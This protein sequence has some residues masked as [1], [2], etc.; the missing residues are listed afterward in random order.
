MHRPMLPRSC[1][2]FRCPAL[3][4]R[5]I[6]ALHPTIHPKPLLAPRQLVRWPRS[7][8]ASHYPAIR[9]PLLNAHRWQSEV[10]C[11]VSS[12][13]LTRIA[14]YRSPSSP[15]I[16]RSPLVLV[17]PVACQH[18]PLLPGVS[19]RRSPTHTLSSYCQRPHWPLPLAI[20]ST[21]LAPPLLIPLYLSSPNALNQYCTCLGPAICELTLKILEMVQYNRSRILWARCL[22]LVNVL[23]KDPDVSGP[24]TSPAPAHTPGPDTAM[25]ARE[26]LVLWSAS[27]NSNVSTRTLHVSIRKSVIY[28]VLLT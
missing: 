14:R 13:Q 11:T 5:V 23:A 28:L 2:L 8:A 12:L 1:G 16:R 3:S 26:V 15:A 19:Y 7:R 21:H 24:S 10:P 6:S 25:R 9:M 22:L 4:T 27:V 18:A 20:L 17:L